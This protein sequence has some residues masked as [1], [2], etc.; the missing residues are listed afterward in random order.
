MQSQTGRSG[1]IDK[2][3]DI[4]LLKDLPIGFAKRNLVLPLRVEDGKLVG[5]VG[6]DNGRL[7]LRELALK[8]GLRPE[9]I[10]ETP[11]RVI[12]EINLAYGQLGSAEDVM[13]EIQ[14]ED[15]TSV[16]TEFESPKDILELTTE[17]PIIRLLNAL[18][19]QAVKERASDIHIEPYERE[20][21]VRMRTDGV[22]RTVL[23]P[24]KV[25]QD[26]LI[27]RVKILAGL[28][29]AEKRL[30]QDGRIRLLVGGRDIDVRVSVVPTVHGE[31]AVLRL[32]D[33]SQGLLGLSELGLEP[34]QAEAFE[35]ALQS[36]SGIILVTGPTGS[37][38]STTLYAA[39]NKIYSVEKNIITIE[40]PVEYQ[41]KGI[42][43]IQVNPRIGLTFASGLRSIL[44]QDPDI[45][46]VG[47]IRDLET[48]QIAVQ[49]SLTG[50]L[51]LSTLHTNDAASAVTR[52]LDMGV[53]PF[54]LGSSLVQVLAQRLVRL[55]CPECKVFYSPEEKELAYFKR[56]GIEVEQLARGRGCSLCKG[57]GYMGR[58]AIFEVLTID[59][60]IRALI[61][62][63]TA[64][65]EIKDLAV[66]KGMR[67]LQVSGLLKAARGETT[68]EEVLRVTETVET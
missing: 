58:T 6:G 8:R 36:T 23:R 25:I 35:R 44:R 20:L 4:S 37:G 22:L 67:S 30:P 31:R 63:A 52:L 13:E 48:A 66:R 43:Q 12:E 7:A 39:L 55:V 61:R 3:P 64:S 51:V 16:A 42:G 21:E 24:P 14:A 46:M 34:E 5:L 60:D 9:A 50:H 15:L 54:L 26:A 53:E 29:I 27:T 62:P 49:A 65:H 17:A 28:D 56:A 38:K 19:Q 68:L 11:E 18:L 47:E 32:L 57:S 41:L 2:T 59:R 40:D 1:L 45:I 33:R 10:E